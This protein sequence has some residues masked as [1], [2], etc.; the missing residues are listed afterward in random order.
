MVWL[1]SPYS[2]I[3]SLSAPSDIF[4]VQLSD[5]HLNVCTV[6]PSSILLMFSADYND[7]TDNSAA[8]LTQLMPSNISITSEKSI[9]EDSRLRQQLRPAALPDGHACHG[10]FHERAALPF[11]SVYYLLASWLIDESVS[12]VDVLVGDGNEWRRASY[13]HGPKWVVWK[14]RLPGI[15]DTWY[16]IVSVT[17]CVEY[18]NDAGGNKPMQK[19]MDWDNPSTLTRNLWHIPLL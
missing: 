11:L 3:L 12:N 5:K 7:L 18:S 17:L 2:D 16:E 6:G 1:L 13:E 19:S 10:R 14:G 15:L 8:I 4:S 9:S